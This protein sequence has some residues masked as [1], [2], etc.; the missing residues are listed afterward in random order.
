M[1]F[2]PAIEKITLKQLDSLEV[3]HLAR[4]LSV[5]SPIA[6]ILCSRG[7][8]SAEACHHF[9]NPVLGQM[10]DPF[11][12]GEMRKAVDRIQKAL[13]NKEK[14][15]VYGDYDVDGVTSTAMMVRL[16]RKFGAD[17]MYYLPNRLIDGYGFS[18]TGIEQIAAEG[19]KLIISVDCGINACDEISLAN[20]LGIDVVVTDHHEP[21]EVSPD[22]VARINPKM[23]GCAYPDKNLAGV[24]VALKLCQALVRSSSLSDDLW[25]E[26]LDL[27][28]L[29]TAADIV[30]LTG[31]NRIITKFGFEQLSK[32]KN[33]GL[34]TLIKQRGL[35]GEAIST[36]QAVFALAPCINAAGR[37]GDPRRG[38]ELM[39]TEDRPQARLYA[40]KLIET[41]SE[42]QSLDSRVEAEAVAWVQESCDPENDFGIVAGNERWHCGV[43]GIVA[44]KIVEKFHRPTILFSIGEDGLARG[45]GRSISGFH[46]M[47]ALTR[48]GGF[49][50]GFGGHKAAAGM[51]IKKENIGKF[52]QAFNE[53]VKKMLAGRD[54][55]PVVNADAEI[56][57]SDINPNFMEH[58]K[59]MEPYGPG[60]MRPVLYCRNL[61]NR[62][63]P[64]IVGRGHLKMLVSDG[65]AAMDAIG[66]NFGDRLD[67]VTNAGAFSLA[68]TLDEN[69]WNGRKNLQMK[70]KGVT[71]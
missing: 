27:A 33:L 2:T 23:P 61:T 35:E 57:L 58:I 41:N 70:L 38:V 60:N 4:E 10:H 53:E 69:F 22:A 48:C 55:V 34:R 7:L 20:S 51:V 40:K 30:P 49:L 31:E 16:L 43:I 29:G 50:E 15:A 68:F 6:S 45:S 24:G 21:K 28:A 11:I 8:K 14:I 59:K 3:D 56:Y 63:A 13:Y 47:E 42:R 36:S 1:K 32:S 9:F 52:R 54:L 5:P 25:V 19:A 12:F 62:Y 46:L 37:L 18:K 17:C 26:Y 67:A 64:R 39:L 44:S 65:R 71:T 66:F